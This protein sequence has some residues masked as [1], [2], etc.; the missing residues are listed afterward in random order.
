MNPAILILI[1]PFVEIIALIEVGRRIGVW[2]TVFLILA[3]SALGGLML[4]RQGMTIIDRARRA[5]AAGESPAAATLDALWTAVAAVLLIVPGFVSDLLA[6][7]LLI[8]PFRRALGAMLFRSLFGGRARFHATG[9]G[10][11]GSDPPGMGDVIDVDFAPVPDE[12][13]RRTTLPAVSPPPEPPVD[14]R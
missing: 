12:P 8:P 10:K 14:H 13:P 11:G 6:V 2:P 4:R 9:F 7:V 1:F 5:A 3:G